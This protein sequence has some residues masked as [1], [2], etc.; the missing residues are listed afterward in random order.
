MFMKLKDVIIDMHQ[1]INTVADKVD[2]IDYGIPIIQSKNFTKGFLDL[3]DVRYLGQE[4]ESKYIDKYNPHVGDILMA[5]IGT[6]GKTFVI[7]KEERFLIAWNAF[8][9]KPNNELV[10]SKFLKF[11]FDYLFSM[12]NITFLTKRY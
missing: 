5:N 8:L 4:D 12:K 10:K 7:E 2:Y 11:Y 6:I 3:N 1:G 9:I